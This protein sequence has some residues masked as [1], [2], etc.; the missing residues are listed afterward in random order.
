MG[1]FSKIEKM[2]FQALSDAD[3]IFVS[4]SVFSVIFFSVVITKTVKNINAY[5]AKERELNKVEERYDQL[6]EHRQNLL[7]HY[8]WSKESGEMETNENIKN[9]LIECDDD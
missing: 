8:Y 1:N 3:P 2:V 5:R 6:C 7:Q 9:D 4:L